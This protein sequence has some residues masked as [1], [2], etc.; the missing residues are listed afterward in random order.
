[1]FQSYDGLR[2]RFASTH[3]ERGLVLRFRAL[4]GGKPYCL[5]PFFES[6]NR[7]SCAKHREE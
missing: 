4:R 2:H 1:M 6:F 7:G 3:N 5:D